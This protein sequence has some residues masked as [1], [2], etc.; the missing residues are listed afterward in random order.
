MSRTE[1]GD[2]VRVLARAVDQTGDV[3][4]HVHADWSGMSTPCG[5]WNLGELVDHLVDGPRRFL[6]MMRGEEVDWSAPP[7]HVAEEWGPAFRVTGD[8]LVHAWHEHSGDAAVSADWQTAELAVHTW[9]VARTIGYP[10]DRL[11]PEVAERGLAFMRENLSED[12]RGP[13]FGPEREVP[14]DAGPYERIAAY[15]GRGID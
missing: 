4:D 1:W 7:P 14:E 6:A 9:D 15:S 12:N 10:V 13:A 11:D 2:E 8:D 3:L 5:D